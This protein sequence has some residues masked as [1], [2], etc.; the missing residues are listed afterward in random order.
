M[1]VVVEVGGDE[2]LA[3]FVGGRYDSCDF[4]S[5]DASMWR[6]IALVE[7]VLCTKMIFPRLLQ[8]ILHVTPLC[9]AITPL[10]RHNTLRQ[11]STARSNF[12]QLSVEFWVGGGVGGLRVR[13]RSNAFYDKNFFF[14]SLS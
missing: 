9:Y 7:L 14:W 2:N 4:L 1:V 12:L 13:G 5:I 11:K 8:I 6:F 10:P 3:Q